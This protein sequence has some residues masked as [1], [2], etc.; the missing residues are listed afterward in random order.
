MLEPARIH[1][2][3]AL[4]L[5]KDERQLPGI[6]CAWAA[7]LP[8]T[9]FLVV[10]TVTPMCLAIPIVIDSVAVLVCIRPMIR[11]VRDYATRNAHEGSE[12][13]QYNY[14]MKC[15]HLL[16]LLEVSASRNDSG[17]SGS[18]DKNNSRAS[19]GAQLYSAESMND[20]LR[21]NSSVVCALADEGVA[22]RSCAM[23]MRTR[24]LLSQV[25]KRRRSRGTAS[26]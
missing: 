12:C 26:I 23:P 15:I 25:E 10:V 5:P 19:G 14:P 11:P 22:P 17:P 20:R 4:L 8:M 6:L 3:C 21:A 1:T 18:L 13:A 9:A 2:Y 24:L 16:I 7:V